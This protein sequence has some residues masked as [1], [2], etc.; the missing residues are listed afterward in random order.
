MKNQITSD[1]ILKFKQQLEDHPIY[2]AV[3]SIEDLQCFM[4]HHVYS[5]WDF[6][7]LIKYLQHQIAPTRYPWTPSYI[8]M[9]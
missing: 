1:I 2:E 5:V 8:K 9:L 3:S 7:S 4:T 6:M